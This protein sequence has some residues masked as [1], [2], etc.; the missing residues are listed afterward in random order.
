MREMV[1]LRVDELE[2]EIFRLIRE[3][4]GRLQLTRPELERWARLRGAALRFTDDG[5]W[6]DGDVFVHVKGSKRY[7]ARWFDKWTPI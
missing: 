2:G 3:D 4:S 7:E 5:V 6:V 1:L